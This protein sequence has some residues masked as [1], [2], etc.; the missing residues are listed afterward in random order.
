MSREGKGG[1]VL[2]TVSIVDGA[3]IAE[4]SLPGLPIVDGMSAARGQLYISLGDGRI[5]CFGADG[6]QAGIGD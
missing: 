4:H 5:V 2:R 6:T 1:S 3:I